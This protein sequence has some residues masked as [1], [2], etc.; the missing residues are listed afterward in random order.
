M[1]FGWEFK[2]NAVGRTWYE[3]AE[4]HQ[5]QLWRPELHKD[6]EFLEEE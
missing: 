5:V 4:L 6:E 1:Q 3:H 2:V